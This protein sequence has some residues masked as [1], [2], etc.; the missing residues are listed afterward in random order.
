MASGASPRSTDNGS[1]EPPAPTPPPWKVEGAPPSDKP[2]PP[3]KGPNPMRRPRWWLVLLAAFALNW[4]LASL[5][6]PS[7]ELA[8]INYTRF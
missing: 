1:S 3:P 5:F 8:T 7:N 4:L 2:V 6:V